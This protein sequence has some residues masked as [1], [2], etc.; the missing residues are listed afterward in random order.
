MES[1]ATAVEAAATVESTSTVAVND[2]RHHIAAVEPASGIA[3]SRRRLYRPSLGD[4][5]FLDDHT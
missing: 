2:C 4:F 3:A 5:R 1:A